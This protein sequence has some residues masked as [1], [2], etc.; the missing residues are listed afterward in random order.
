MHREPVLSVVV[1]AGRVPISDGHRDMHNEFT[2]AIA[3][4]GLAQL[5]H[6]GGPVWAKAADKRLPA[7]SRPNVV[8]PSPRDEHLVL[9]ESGA[10]LSAPVV[11]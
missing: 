9:I 10:R 5:G 1:L 4:K 3:K 2:V 11:S 7:V 6:C 8:I